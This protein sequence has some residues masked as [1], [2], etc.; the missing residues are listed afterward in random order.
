MSRLWDRVSFRGDGPG[1]VGN[2]FAADEVVRRLEGGETW[3]A[4]T[5]ATGLEP[6]DVVAALAAGALGD[7]GS[8]G[9]TLTR[10]SP[11]HP[12]LLAALSE[13]ALP[14]SLKAD[15][16]ARLALAAGL[17]QVHDFWDPSHAAAQDAD[18]VG[19]RGTSAY[20]HAVAHRREPDYGNAAYWSRRVGRHPV[21]DALACDAKD[22]DGSD[23]ADLARLTPSWTSMGL[24]ELCAAARPGTAREA[25]ARRAQRVEMLRLLE[26]SAAAVGLV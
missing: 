21:F 19:E 20:W 18:D 24:I 9:P 12:R 22:L 8:P 11:R 3:D 2:G 15:R 4:L 5:K 13:P 17:L 23:P 26:A 10:S 6:A 1:V 14:S 7:D 25:L 16:G